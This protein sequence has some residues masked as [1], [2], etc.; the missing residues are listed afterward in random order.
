M[1]DYVRVIRMTVI[2]GQREWVE[3]T[4]DLSIQGTKIIDAKKGNK[5]T[6][7]TVGSFPEILDNNRECSIGIDY[8]NCSSKDY[9]HYCTTC[10][11]FK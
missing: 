5:V 3:E 10:V 6:S 4:L 1:S 11:N 2:E 7:V 9:G 8:D